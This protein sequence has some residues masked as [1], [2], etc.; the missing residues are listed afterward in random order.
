MTD[1]YKT[2]ID[3]FVLWGMSTEKVQAALILGSQARED[4][5]ADEYSDLDIVMFVDDPEYFIESD[6]WLGKF[7]VYHV[8][9]VENTIDG[10][11]ERRVL[12]DGACDVDFIIQP[13]DSYKSIADS[14]VA[15]ILLRGYSIIIDKIGLK[16]K[17]EPLTAVK[18]TY[19]FPTEQAFL[20]IIND[21]WYHAVWTAKKLKRGE[22]WTAKSCLDSYMKWRLLTIIEC[23]A[24]AR[25]GIDYDTWY[26]G[27]FLERWA[28][29]W[30]IEDLEK[31]FALYDESSIR[32][33]LFSTMSLFR[34]I[35]I[36]V[37]E[38]LGYQYPTS[39]DEYATRYVTSLIQN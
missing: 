18:P 24:R 38:K 22:R 30:I 5:T 28:E 31:C 12:F 23:Y 35:A 1:R 27:R 17:L 13:L 33:A 9:F 19:E 8:T 7:G 34:V 3:N 20:G 37:A 4:C 26:S 36:K 32:D 21:F 39:A 10:G 2:L 25:Y 11:Q 6:H 29:S 14:K 15:F 16:D